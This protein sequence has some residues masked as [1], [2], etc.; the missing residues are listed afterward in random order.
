[1]DNI[2][3]NKGLIMCTRYAFMPNKLEYC[4]SKNYQD[5]FELGT[6]KEANPFLNK[7][8]QEFQTLY[9]YLKLIATS[10]NIRDP[11]D[12]RV[13][14]AY[15]IGNELLENTDTKKL[16]LHFS[17]SLKLK[18]KLSPK[19]FLN[20]MGKIPSKTKPHHSFHVF[21]L[22]LR[23]GHLPI[24]H[25]LQTMNDCIIGWGKITKIIGHELEIK[26]P[27]LQEKNEKIYLSP[28]QTKKVLFKILGKSFIEKP[29]VNDYIS[30]HWNFACDKLD[31]K[32]VN[33][34]KKY[35]LINLNI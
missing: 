14:E 11:F 1:M 21:N 28:P 23:T 26:T 32:Q 19:Q 22:W 29:K 33:N 34:L 12:Y 24:K 20:L 3:H 17:D 13:V 35:T 15:W 27:V 8:L 10:N 30:Y 25:T 2:K 4:G 31:T 9:P 7:L 16:Y 18:K 6:K 5:L